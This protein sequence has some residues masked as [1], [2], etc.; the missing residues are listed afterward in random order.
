MA[1]QGFSEPKGAGPNGSP[2]P[3]KD[4][5][6][7][8]GDP[9][10]HHA[11]GAVDE[12]PVSNSSIVGW[13]VAMAV[14]FFGSAAVL[15]S[16]FARLTDDAVNER[17][18]SV[19]SPALQELRVEE[20]RRLST[21]GYVDKDKKLIHVPIEDGIKQVIAEAQAQGRSG[22][23]EQKPQAAPPQAPKLEV[24]PTAVPK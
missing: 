1:E 24:A 18:L 11:S 15:S 16:V 2:V 9:S 6:G 14:L 5:H 3:H 22:G 20:Q 13:G 12:T 8:H 10:A 19:S 21:Y 23:P 17:V 7:D 4:D